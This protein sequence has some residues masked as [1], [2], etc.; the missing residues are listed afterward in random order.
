MRYACLLSLRLNAGCGIGLRRATVEIMDRRLVSAVVQSAASPP[1]SLR[2]FFNL[3][4]RF[5]STE[6]SPSRRLTGL[7]SRRLRKLSVIREGNFET[8]DSDTKLKEQRTSH[9]LSGVSDDGFK[10]AFTG[11]PAERSAASRHAIRFGRRASPCASLADR[12]HWCEVVFCLLH[13]KVSTSPRLSRPPP[14]Y[15]R[16]L[17]TLYRPRRPDELACCHSPPLSRKALWDG[18]TERP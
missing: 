13:D 17:A 5:P 16:A 6:T 15:A 1:N 3:C 7:R 12:S 14:S 2:D 11:R 4:R 10:S 8:P 9:S 18:E